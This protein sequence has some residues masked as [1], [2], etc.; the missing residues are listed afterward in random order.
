MTEDPTS[1]TTPQPTNINSTQ[2]PVVA[3]TRQPT[4][5]PTLRASSPPRTSN[6]SRFPTLRPSTSFMP[7][8]HPTLAITRTRTTSS[9]RPNHLP[10]THPTSTHSP[11]PLPTTTTKNNGA[12]SVQDLAYVTHPLTFR[13]PDEQL[14]VLSSHL[15]HNLEEENFVFSSDSSSSSD[16]PSYI[17]D[18]IS[19]ASFLIPMVLIIVGCGLMALG[20]TFIQKEDK[21]EINKII[22]DESFVVK[23]RV[24]SGESIEA[25][26][27]PL[28]DSGLMIDDKKNT[29][30]QENDF[31]SLSLNISDDG[32]DRGKV[33]EEFGSNNVVKEGGETLSGGSVSISSADLEEMFSVPSSP[34]SYRSEINSD[35]EESSSD[36]DVHSLIKRGERL[37]Y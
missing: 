36:D 5:T 17:I 32:E 33:E 13:T 14:I 15:R 35:E 16:S 20:V 34:R 30:I 4:R 31:R 2:T 25:H 6:P 11:S 18:M 10:T 29:D 12:Y 8:R 19:S 21:D 24:A 23:E 7:T 27:I 1:F 9:P 37:F 26:N 28:E 22:E 3:P